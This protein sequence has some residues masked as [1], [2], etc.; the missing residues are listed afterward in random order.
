M[1]EKFDVLYVDFMVEDT[2]KFYCNKLIDTMNKYSTSVVVEK[3]DYICYSTS[4]NHRVIYIKTKETVNNYPIKAR[5]AAIF[6]YINTIKKIKQFEF[7]KIIVL[8]YDPIVFTLYFHNLLKLGEVYLVQHHQLDEV[9]SSRI[10]LKIWN[11]YKDKV[12]HIM[13]DKAIIDGAIEKFNLDSRR[14]YYFPIPYVEHCKLSNNNVRNNIVVLCISGSNEQSQINKLI[15]IEKKNHFLESNHISIVIKERTSKN[16]TGL[17]A[18]RIVEDHLSDAEYNQLYKECDIVLMLFPQSY[19][20]RCSGTL[21]DAFSYGKKVI[22]SNITQSAYYSKHFPSLCT[23]FDSIE[24]IGKLILNISKL[25]SK[26]DLKKFSNEFA[27]IEQK[28]A[29]EILKT[30][31]FETQE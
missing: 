10:K 6:N 21:I 26:S 11:L 28:C 23:K 2:H 17:R 30:E 5:I 12:N 29:K 16:A 27:N 25:D 19:K 4:L 20:Y 15:E 18:F 3:K 7:N 9:A 1:K 14:V 22:S 8:G 24:D 31:K 13:L